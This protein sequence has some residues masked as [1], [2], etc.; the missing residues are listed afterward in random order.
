MAK[1]NRNKV[2]A[3]ETRQA[4][5]LADEILNELTAGETAA[6]HG[7]VRAAFRAIERGEYAG[8]MGR[9]GLA[10]LAAGVKSRGRKALAERSR[11]A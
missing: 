4:R 11:K 8:Y 3:R 5:S 10:R 2:K 1:L 9:E 6:V 7:R